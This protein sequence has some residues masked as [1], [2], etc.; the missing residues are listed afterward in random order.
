MNED[1]ALNTA[2]KAIQERIDASLEADKRKERVDI[3]ALDFTLKLL[4]GEVLDR[5][6][7]E[8]NKERDQSEIISI[9]DETR[10]V[11]DDLVLNG[12]EATV[13][14]NQHFVRTVWGR[15]G[16][17]HEVITNITHR[18]LWVNTSRGWLQRHIDELEQGPTFVDGRLYEID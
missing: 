10:I 9:S 7:L 1:T 14:T 17:P 12:D 8:Q 5:Q 4:S 18:E 15:D 6:Q 3:M 11:I 16:L 2:R 13:H